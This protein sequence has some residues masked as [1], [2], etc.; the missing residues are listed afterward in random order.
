MVPQLTP[1]RQ[2]YMASE[3]MRLI[4]WQVSGDTS[5]NSLVATVTGTRTV[6][7]PQGHYS[8]VLDTAN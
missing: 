5:D 3:D 7:Y 8:R 2:T 4:M 6:W 1:C